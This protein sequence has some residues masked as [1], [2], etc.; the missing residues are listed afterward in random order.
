ML[1]AMEGHADCA[2][3]LLDAG[4]DAN[5]KTKVRVCRFCMWSLL[6]G[7]VATNIFVFAFSIV[8]FCLC[9]CVPF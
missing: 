3:L 1:A 4:A 5:A 2:R 7:A 9:F 6:R 8:L